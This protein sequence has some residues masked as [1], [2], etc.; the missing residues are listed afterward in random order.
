MRRYEPPPR[1]ATHRRDGLER[2]L[3]ASTEA[4]DLAQATIARSHTLAREVDRAKRRSLEERRASRPRA[5]YAL[6]EGVVDGAPVSAVVRR[7]G[8]VSAEPSLLARAQLVVALRDTVDG[9]RR[10]ATLE[11]DPLAVTLTIARACDRVRVVRMVVAGPGAGTA[12]AG[13]R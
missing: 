12:A 9:G 4:R 8:S 13:R 3:S 1:R 7:D 10:G 5:R 6:V 11:D 2:L